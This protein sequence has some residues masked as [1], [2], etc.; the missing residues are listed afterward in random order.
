MIEK[1]PSQ[2]KPQKLLLVDALAIGKNQVLDRSRGS[3]EI[4]W[5]LPCPASSNRNRWHRGAR[6][7]GWQVRPA[8]G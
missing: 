3:I 5:R 1:L 6:A 8:R 4:H 2:G 7:V